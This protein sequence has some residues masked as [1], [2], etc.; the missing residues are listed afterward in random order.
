MDIDIFICLFCKI[1]IQLKLEVGHLSN[2]KILVLLSL[3]SQEKSKPARDW[4]TGLFT[5]LIQE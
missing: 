5:Q 1:Y 2:K 4:N 3:R